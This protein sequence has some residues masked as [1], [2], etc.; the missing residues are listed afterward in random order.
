MTRLEELVRVLDSRHGWTDGT[1]WIQVLG[2][3]DDYE[4]V[5]DTRLD[6]LLG[7]VAPPRC[8]AIGMTALGLARSTEP[9]ADCASAPRQ[10]VRITCLV[11][12]TGEVAGRISWA[13][14]TQVEEPPQ[15]GRSLD[16]LRRCLGLATEPPSVPS[17]HLVAA[18]W[19]DGVSRMAERWTQPLSWDEVAFQHP[20]MQLAR[21]ARL[22]IGPDDLAQVAREAQ[23]AWTWTR[24]LHQASRPGPLAD[25]LPPGTGGWMD[26]GMLARWL[27]APYPPLATQLAGVAAQL[28]PATARRLVGVLAL[29]GLP[30]ECSTA[31]GALGEELLDLSSQVIADRQRRSRPR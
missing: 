1:E 16:I 12:R 18:Q 27:L 11:A 24:L 30:T 17:T 14:G 6:R 5:A 20:A 4:L 28:I 25:T 23:R 26:E 2:T 29:L 13:D 9:S 7:F 3:V 10:R 8:E 31:V 15:S 22:P 21:A 19:L